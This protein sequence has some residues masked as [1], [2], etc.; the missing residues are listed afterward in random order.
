MVEHIASHSRPRHQAQA[1]LL[2]QKSLHTRELRLCFK[3][4]EWEQLMGQILAKVTENLRT[5]G[6]AETKSEHQKELSSLELLNTL[7]KN[8]RQE[9]LTTD[10]SAVLGV[11][12]SQQ[13]RL[14][15]KLQ[16]EEHSTGTG[17]SRLHDLY[18]QAMKLLGVQRPKSEKDAKEVP[19]ATQ[20]PVSMKRKKKGFLPETKKRKKRKSEGAVQGEAAPAAT[21]GDQPPAQARRGGTSGR[22]RSQ[23]RPRSTGCLL[24]RVQPQTP[25]P[26]P[27]PKKRKRKQS[28]VNGTLLPRVRPQTPCADPKAAKAK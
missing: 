13:P 21:G 26:A 1:C 2:L 7:F 25:R 4:P 27:K 15:Q 10:L 28:Q 22:P 12:Q 3:A 24:P 17:S 14:Q 23:P 9:K 8:I 20:N 6:E 19:E 11:L 5:L 16:Q 18:W